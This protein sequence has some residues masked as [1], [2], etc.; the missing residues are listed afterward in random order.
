MI[1][2]I[3]EET[4]LDGSK[5]FVIFQ[6]SSHVSNFLFKNYK[7]SGVDISGQANR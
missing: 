1:G 4:Q 2:F 3:Q 7:N 6:I 5:I